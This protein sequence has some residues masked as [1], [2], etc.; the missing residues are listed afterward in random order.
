MR[1]SALAGTFKLYNTSCK[2][3]PLGL[4]LG[5]KCTPSKHRPSWR[6]IRESSHR[7]WKLAQGPSGQGKLGPRHREWGFRGLSG[8]N[9]ACDLFIHLGWER[10][11]GVK[12]PGKG[13]MCPLSMCEAQGRTPSCQVHPCLAW[14]LTHLVAGAPLLMASGV[15][16]LGRFGQISTGKLNVALVHLQC[17]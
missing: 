7:S 1:V 16:S 12:W 6:Q 11:K 3:L 9:S 13:Q 15:C 10:G 8:C 17:L 5:L 4:F 2:Q 14:C